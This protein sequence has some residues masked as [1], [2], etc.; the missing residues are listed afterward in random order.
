M[1]VRSAFPVAALNCSRLQG[2]RRC[3]YPLGDFITNTVEDEISAEVR[4]HRRF[5]A[6][7]HEEIACCDS[8]DAVEQDGPHDKQR[9]ELDQRGGGG[10]VAQTKD[11]RCEN[12]G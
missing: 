2:Y 11:H 5:E 10:Q 1:N 8:Y 4:Q 12:I 6:I 7:A 3:A 9:G